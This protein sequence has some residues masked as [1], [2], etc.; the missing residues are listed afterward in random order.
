MAQMTNCADISEF[1]TYLFN[2]G[3]NFKSYEML[4]VH[5]V[6]QG[7]DVGFRFSV[8]APNAKS[9]SLVGDFNDWKYPD[10][11]LEKLG[12]CG[13]WCGF[14]TDIKEG[15]FYKY[16]IEGADGEVYLKADP[17]AFEA[18]LRPGT[19]SVVK[20]LSPYKWTDAS[21]L[22]KR[23]SNNNIENLD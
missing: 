17:Y 16:A 12:S 19:A 11:A 20:E 8:W 7:G 2:S 5:K 22:K 9:V 14:F 15:A 18:E 6:S 21:W 10:K 1:Q 4:G 13:I 3:N 23:A